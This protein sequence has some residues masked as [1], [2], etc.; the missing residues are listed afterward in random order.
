MRDADLPG[1]IQEP[2]PD[3]VR[4]TVE[5]AVRILDR[6]HAR[7]RPASQIAGK[8]VGVADLHTLDV[9]RG[10]KPHDPALRI[11]GDREHRRRCELQ[12]G[13]DTA[14]MDVLRRDLL[15][16]R[17][18]RKPDEYPECRRFRLQD[19]EIRGL[20]LP[21]D[22]IQLHRQHQRPQGRGYVLL[23]SE[24]RDVRLR[25]R[26]VEQRRF[27]PS[28]MKRE[29]IGMRRDDAPCAAEVRGR[30]AASSLT[31]GVA[32]Q[33][34]EEH[35]DVRHVVSATAAPHAA[36]FRYVRKL[37]ECRP[38]TLRLHGVTNVRRACR[39]GAHMVHVLG[40]RQTLEELDGA[41]GPPGHIPRK[42]FQHERRALPPTVGER[43]RHVCAH[44]DAGRFDGVDRPHAQQVA[45]VRHHPL[46]AR[47]DEPVVVEPGD[48]VFDAPE[49][50]VERPEQ[51]AKRLAA[52]RVPQPVHRR[53]VRVEP[54]GTLCAHRVIS[55]SSI[56]TGF[57]SSNS[58]GS[59]ARVA[60]SQ[61]ARRATSGGSSLRDIGANEAPSSVYGAR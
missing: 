17:R 12:L 23:P 56:P 37:A 33:A 20:R 11:D 55:E 45:D 58:A 7:V 22:E 31:D 3:R 21:A 30:H 9:E 2:R 36:H 5:R 27:H 19:R 43:V 61:L 49:L 24:V 57:T 51:R 1:R 39:R 40:R 13:R 32:L 4:G 16:F 52:R 41:R 60:A 47:F 29:R 35:T 8:A 28:R 50:C 34:P 14:K 6:S 26:N 38:R 15:G 18:P 48:V 10:G 59:T 25:H 46:V 44:T 53:Q 42:L 54:L